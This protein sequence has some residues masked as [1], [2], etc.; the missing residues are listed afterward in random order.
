[1]ISSAIILAAGG[2]MVSA[3]RLSDDRTVL[4][5]LFILVGGVTWAL[6]RLMSFR[7]QN[8]RKD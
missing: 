5:F 7:E 8:L 1:M 6:D 3:N 2:L 4:G